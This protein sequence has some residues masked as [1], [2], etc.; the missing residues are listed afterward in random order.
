MKPLKVHRPQ[1]TFRE[2]QEHFGMKS[3]LDLRR[4][5]ITGVIRPAAH[6]S[7]LLQP[8][9][10]EGDLPV[11]KQ[12]ELTRVRGWLWPAVERAEQVDNFETLYRLVRDRP[13][14]SEEALYWALPEPLTLTQ[15]LVVA[16]VFD[17]NIK[18][19]EQLQRSDPDR[20]PTGKEERMRDKLITLLA[21][22][23][24]GWLPW[25][26]GRDMQLAGFLEAANEHRLP[27]SRNAV[28]R[29]LR[30]AWERAKPGPEK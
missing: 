23:H 17:E 8:V 25:E 1:W 18:A 13:E 19:I 21:A 30:L 7:R 24:L 12:E 6:F 10:F 20:E 3:D 16:V 5:V 29:H 4:L 22:E 26:D 9:Q 11:V 14:H 28:K 2:V 15:L 27:M